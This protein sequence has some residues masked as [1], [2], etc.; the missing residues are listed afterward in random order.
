MR[1][2]RETVLVKANAETKVTLNL[3]VG[4]RLA[5]SFF[6]VNETEPGGSFLD[7]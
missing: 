5:G 4:L 2:E 1:L 7:N 3:G 6:V